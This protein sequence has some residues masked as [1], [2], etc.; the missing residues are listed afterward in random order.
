MEGSA[1]NGRNVRSGEVIH[2]DVYP[3][4]VIYDDG[5][6]LDGQVVLHP[7]HGDSFGCDAMPHGGCGLEGGCDGWCGDAACGDHAWRPCITLCFPQS[8]WVSFEYLAWWQDGMS[9]PPLVTSNRGT[10]IPGTDAG[11]LGRGSTVT[12]FGGNRV[13]RDAF[14]G[15]RLRFGVWLDR[16]QTWGLGAEVFS[17]GTESEGFERTSSGNPILARPFFNTRLGQEDSELVAFPGVISGT[18]AATAQSQLDGWGVHFRRLRDC[19]EGCSTPLFGSVPESFQDRTEFLFGYRGLQLDE[20]VTVR[21]DLVSGNQERFDMFDRFDTRNQ[22]NGFDI[23]WSHRRTRGY[24]SLDTAIRLAFGNTRQTVTIDGQT[25]IVDPLDPPAQTLPG[26]LLAQQSNIGTY[27][28][29][30]FSVVPEI[31]ANLGFHLTDHLTLR[32]GYTFIYWSNIARPGEHI[33]RDVNPD[34]LPPPADPV[35]GGLRPEFRWDT[36]DY[37]VQGINFGGEYR[38]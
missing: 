12:L 10:G 25:T 24:W 2:G 30:R 20:R 37:W 4:E 33:S 8:G 27:R 23:G 9:L 14:D 16:R 15:G 36:V 22:F 34:L 18:V 21:E 17:L 38:W 7:F 31:N 19:R 35:N 29:D 26:G 5:E 13:L 6:Y 11:V 1:P 3:G 32:V 28:Q